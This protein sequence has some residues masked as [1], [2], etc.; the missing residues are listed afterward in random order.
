MIIKK[1]YV[2][3]WPAWLTSRF[4]GNL[5]LF[6]C[7]ILS[8]SLL[9]LFEPNKYLLLHS[10]PRLHVSAYSATVTVRRGS[11][12]LSKQSHAAAGHRYGAR[13]RVCVCVWLRRRATL[14]TFIVAFDQVPAVSM[15]VHGWRLSIISCEG[16]IVID[17]QFCNGIRDVWFTTLTKKCF[18]QLLVVLF[19]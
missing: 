1:L 4:S 12:G 18:F 5:A 3:G 10:A 2:F 15:A 11:F 16:S 17:N 8:Y 7:Y 14:L 13:A 9:L 19:N 6:K